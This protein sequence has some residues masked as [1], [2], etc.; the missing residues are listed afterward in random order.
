MFTTPP[1]PVL[2]A[3]TYAVANRISKK[4]YA[5]LREFPLPFPAESPTS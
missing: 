5:E 2:E 1:R 4:R 3:P